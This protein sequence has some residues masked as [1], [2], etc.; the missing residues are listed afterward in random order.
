MDKELYSKNLSIRFKTYSSDMK[1]VWESY[2]FIN[3]YMSAIHPL[4]KKD[5]LPPFSV[6]PLASKNRKERVI[7]KSRTF[8]YKDHILKKVNPVRS[9]ISSVS[10]TEDF[11]QDMVKIVYTAYPEKLS[12]GDARD[13]PER[14]E[15]V[16]NVILQSQNKEEIIDRLIEE[17]VRGIFYGN[18]VNFFL[19]DKK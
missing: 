8:G 17:K 5:I 7:N 16:I 11:L 6:V 12:G 19:K 4:I 2:V 13:S 15:K 14:V 1:D 3:K 9:L 18:P 10:L